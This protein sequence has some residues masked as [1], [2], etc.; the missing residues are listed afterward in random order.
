MLN[1]RLLARAAALGLL[2]LL[3]SPALAV[4]VRSWSASTEEGFGKGTLDGTALDEEARVRLAPVRT[5]LWG[6][7]EGIV[8]AVEAAGEADAFV[9]LSGP[10]RVLRVEA[11]AEP[12]VWFRAA[13]ESLV[14]TMVAD[15]SGGVFFGLSPEGEVYHA[16][17]AGQVELLTPTEA[18]FVWGLGVDRDG[19]LWIGTGSPGAVLRRTPDGNVERL[20]DAGDDPVRCLATHPGGGVVFGTG[21][22]GRVVRLGRDGR[23]FVLLDAEEKEIV[24]VVVSDEGTVY[25]LAATGSKQVSGSSAAADNRLTETVRVVATAPANGPPEEGGPEQEGRPTPRPRSKPPALRS[26]IGGALYRL[27]SDGSWRAIW[28]A[29]QEMPFAMLRSEAGKLLVSTGDAGRIFV[30]DSEGRSARLLNIPSE[31]A[32]AMSLGPGGRILVGGTSDARVE[33]LGPEP[34]PSG[35]YLSPAI[36]AGSVADWG[37]V[38]WE[39]DLP[40]GTELALEARSGNTAEP[41]DTWHDWVALPRGSGSEGV[42]TGVPPARWFQV[43]V[44]L[45]ARRDESPSLGRLEVFYQPRNRPPVVDQLTVEPSG[46]VWV[47][48]PTQSSARLGPIVVDDPV[49]RRTTR[50]LMAGRRAGAPIRKAY[51]AGARTFSWKAEDPDGDRLLYTLEI[52]HEGEPH[53]FLLAVDVDRHYFSWDA[54]GMPDG[55]YR[56]RLT[57]GDRMDNPS[58]AVLSHQRVSDVFRIDN[59]RPSVDGLAIDSAEAGYEVEFVALDP[60]GSVAAVEVALDG[61]QWQPLNPLDGVADSEREQYRLVVESHPAASALRS[62]TVRVTDAAGNLGGEMWLLE[63]E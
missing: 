27:D 19:S 58:G 32:S 40:R 12:E 39:A 62:L 28:N 21:G 15:G 38:R 55:L 25:A 29:G 24:S 36:D 63:V 49:A 41:D 4:S 18:T 1:E 3:G 43:R 61:G 48:G 53:W 16:R 46:V 60:E 42:E 9:A 50:T 5:T 26:P 45:V 14:T 54:R 33:L 51:E 22:R 8:W 34:R 17:G 2:A 59:T 44:R 7:E 57:A 47:R 23:P 35:S 13:E 56:V 31:Q 10:G 30:L 20:F 11:G 52:R 6:P 37:R